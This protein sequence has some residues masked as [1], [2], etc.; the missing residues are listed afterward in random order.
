MKLQLALDVLTLQD[1][2]SLARSVEDCVDRFEMGPPCLLESGMEAG[3]RFRR[4]LGGGERLPGRS[5]FRDRLG[6]H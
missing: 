3:R 5:R 1:A 4:R 6:R 2:L